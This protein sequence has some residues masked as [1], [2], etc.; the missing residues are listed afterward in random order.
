VALSTKEV[1]IQS[2]AGRSALVRPMLYWRKPY[3]LDANTTLKGEFINDN[4]EAAGRLVYLCERPNLYKEIE[5][6]ETV[7][8]ELLIDLGL[9]G[10][11]TQTG[12]A[13]SQ[14]VG[15]DLLIYGAYSTSTGMTVRFSDT[16]RNQAWSAQQLPIGAFAG[17]HGQIQPIMPYPTPYFLPRNSSILAEW[18][19][20]GAE[21]GEFVTFIC[22]RI[23][24]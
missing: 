19:N 16:S 10:G 17:I 21:S 4:S 6:R 12:S 7:G 9:T 13:K 14:Q 2:I 11:A 23:I 24:R 1:P 8:Y 20:A 22:E 15:Y 5:V 18:T 3:L